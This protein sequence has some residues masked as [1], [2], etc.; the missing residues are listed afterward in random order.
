MVTFLFEENK[1]KN[2]HVRFNKYCGNTD[3][4][5]IQSDFNIKKKEKQ[6]KVLLYNSYITYF[7]FTIFKYRKH[8]PAIS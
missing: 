4:T 3:Q 8:L 7:L 5:N 6:Q 2:K 1:T